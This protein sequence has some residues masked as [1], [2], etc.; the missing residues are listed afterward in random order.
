MGGGPAGLAALA[1]PEGPT[2]S[3][4]SYT[5]PGPVME[6]DRSRGSRS[7]FVFSGESVSEFKMQPEV[8]KMVARNSISSFGPGPSHY[9]TGLQVLLWS[10]CPGVSVGKCVCAAGTRASKFLFWSFCFGV[11]VSEFML[12]NAFA[13]PEA[14]CRSLYVGLSVLEFLVWSSCREMR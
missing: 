4:A 14:A 12:G 11:S 3:A 7:H 6:M 5:S 8:V 9:V 13:Q 1:G 2:F 10:A